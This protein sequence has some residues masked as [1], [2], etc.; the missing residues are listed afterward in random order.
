MVGVRSGVIVVV[1]VAGVG[2][3]PA[4][5]AAGATPTVRSGGT[6]LNMRA[7]ASTADA[8]AG[9]LREGAR[10]TVTCQVYGELIAGTQGRTPMWNRL[11]NGRYVADAYVHWN[12]GRPWV[13]WCGPR[14]AVLPTVR[15]GIGPLNVRSGPGTRF[16]R[17]GRIAEGQVLAV[18]CQVWGELVAGKVRR[19]A[20]W[21][22]LPGGRYV[23]DAYTVW[24]PHLPTLPWC[25]QQ[26][27]STPAA[28]AAQFIART[29]GPARAGFRQYKVPASVTIAQAIL[30]SGWGRS[31]L[32][33]RDHSYFGIKCF[34]NPGGIAL[35][36]R[37]YATHECDGKK[38]YPTTAQFRAYRNAN[39]SFADH[40]RFLTVN[41]RYRNAFRYS[42]DPNRFAVE[43]HKAGYAT[44]PTYAQNLIKLMKAHNLYRFDR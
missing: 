22:R 41:P 8:V 16:A 2:V 19:S 12:P 31:W 43:I 34:G 7:G 21:N 17:V 20:A 29:S 36:C 5:Q 28:N 32:A 25:G 9:R 40:G 1:L 30:E 10:L 14:G 4:A 24:S 35:G 42:H 15:T 18:E 44:S 11:S 27:P 33:R 37:S 38:C 39:G 3:A 23:A 26:A 6:G 13:H